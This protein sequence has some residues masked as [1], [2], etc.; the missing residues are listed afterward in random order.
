MLA[1]TNLQKNVR[2]VKIISQF[3]RR[4]VFYFIQYNMYNALRRPARR[5]RPVQ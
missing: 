1:F 5:R 3:P 4:V 2:T